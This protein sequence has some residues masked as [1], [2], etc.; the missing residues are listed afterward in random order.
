MKVTVILCTY[1]RSQSL[2]RALLSVAHSIVPDSIAWEV[3]VVDNNS[4]D[5]TREVVEEF[6]RSYPQRFRYLFEARQ[7]KSHAL[8]SGIRATDA[9]VLAFMDDDVEVDAHWLGNLTKVFRSDAWSGV[10]GRIIAEAGFVPPRWMETSGRYALAP[11]AFFDL[12][13]KAGESKEAPFGTNMAF[14]KEVFQKYGDFRTDLGPQP[15]SEIRNEDTEF[16]TRLLNAGERIWYEP[17]ALVFHSVPRDRIRKDYFLSWWFDKARAEVR[18]D[19]I[20]RQSR[21]RIGGVPVFLFRTLSGWTLRWMTSVDPGRR[22][23]CKLNVWKTAGLI[24]E[25]RRQ[26]K[27]ASLKAAIDM[28]DVSHAPRS[29]HDG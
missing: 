19:G 23:S 24:Q 7:G 20:P 15:G 3:L 2:T 5:K 28:A 10:G 29:S 9:G 17:T 26:F 22:F 6:C 12:G 11:L 1:N 8:N 16:G 14:R 4:A 25:C 18:Q 21:L 13:E 27:L